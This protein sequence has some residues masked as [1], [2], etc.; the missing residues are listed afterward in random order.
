MCLLKVT[1]KQLEDNRIDFAFRDE[2]AG[3]LIPLNKC[4]RATGYAMW[5]CTDLRHA[6][7][8][9]QFKRYIKRS[10]SSPL[11]LVF[12]LT[13]CFMNFAIGIRNE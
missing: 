3:I 2:C 9:C 11:V 7:E 5:K 1:L 13:E 8:G 4:R 12:G 10:L 6:Y